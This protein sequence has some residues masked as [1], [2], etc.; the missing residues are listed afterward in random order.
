MTASMRG[1]AAL[2]AVG[3]VSVAGW[4]TARAPRAI[5]DLAAEFSIDRN[6]NGPWEYGFS[7]GASLAPD[8]LR[9]FANADARGTIKF[10]HP[11][12]ADN[13]GGD[14]YPYAAWNASKQARADPTASWAIRPGE[15]ALEASNVGQYAIVRFVVPRRG[16]YRIKARFVGVHFRLSSTD[17]HVLVRATPVFDGVVDGYGGDPAFHAIE[18][19]APRAA[20]SGAVALERGDAVTFAVGYGPNRTHFNDTT[21]LRA[22]I[23]WVGSVVAT[24]TGDARADPGE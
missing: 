5:H 3:V 18:G 13:A 21:A 8:Q 15:I 14:Y 17:V 6:P 9:R 20:W 7:A 19:A 11:A 2:A 24:A 16:R 12:A 10:W 1:W 22:R 23:R 4:A